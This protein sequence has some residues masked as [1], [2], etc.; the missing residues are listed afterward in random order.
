MSKNDVLAKNSPLED[1]TCYIELLKQESE[2]GKVLVSSGFLE[3]QL[4][5]VLRAFM[6]RQ[7]RT[8]EELVEPDGLLGTL[9]ARTNMCYALGLITK[10]EHHDL[11]LIGNIRNKFAHNIK[12]TFATPF[13]IEKCK[14]L[15]YSLEYIH[16]PDGEKV[17]F[18]AGWQFIMAS[19]RLMGDLANRA[20][21]VSQ[22]SCK[23]T[24]W[25]VMNGPY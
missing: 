10:S 16:K 20:R 18:D 12:T 11:M 13:V 25:N 19:V 8:V 21:L 23:V 6:I 15:R 1:F 5:N 3:E 2:R 14:E 24:D 22:K 7:S 17:V 4:K 9:S